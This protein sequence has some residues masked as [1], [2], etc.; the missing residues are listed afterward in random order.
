M[1]PSQNSV[2][3]LIQIVEWYRG[4][5]AQTKKDGVKYGLEWERIGIFC[6]DK[7]P[8]MYLGERGY[9]QI[10]NGLRDEF[11]WQEVDVEDGHVFTL[12]KGN[13]LVTTE[14]DGKPEISGAPHASLI[15]VKK[16]LQQVGEEIDYFADPLGIS[17]QCI[18]ISALHDHDQIQLAP[19]T[20]Y[21]IWD[22]IFPDYHDWMHRYMKNLCGCHINLGVTSEADLICKTQTLYRLTPVLT[23]VFANAAMEKGE[24]TPYKSVRRH[25]IFNGSF[26]RETMPQGILSDDFSLE[27]WLDF[28][29]KNDIYII[30]KPSGSLVPKRDLKSFTFDDFIVQGYACEQAMLQDVD[31]HIKTH[32]VDIRPRMGYLEYRPLDSLPLRYFMAAAAFVKGVCA[33]QTNMQKVAELTRVWEESDYYPTLNVIAYTDGA[34]GKYKGVKFTDLMAALMPTV[35]AALCDEE[36]SLL[37]PL[38]HLIEHSTCPADEFTAQGICS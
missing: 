2:T 17:W 30:N 14:A 3:D 5:F 8:V 29:L 6:E 32:W 24:I 34:K 7:A 25:H 35:E 22:E 11:G 26:G 10:I 37:R 18:G 12:R 23:G 38:Q 20:R 9:Q 15:D 28:F 16:E 31:V 36:R 1:H 27:K 21:L 13:V 19:K 4:L 33:T